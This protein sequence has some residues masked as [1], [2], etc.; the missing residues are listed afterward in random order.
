MNLFKLYL[1][2]TTF[3]V[4]I[5]KFQ[6]SSFIKINIRITLIALAWTLYNLA[7][8]NEWQEKCREEIFEIVGDNEVIERSFS[9]I[10]FN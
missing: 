6:R 9:K 4:I 10:C 3:F 8:S 1:T 5:R 2:S 7:K